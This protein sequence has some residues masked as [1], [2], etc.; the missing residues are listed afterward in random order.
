MSLGVVVGDL[1]ASADRR[2]KGGMAR[3]TGKRRAEMV[4]VSG[5]GAAGDAVLEVVF[6]AP[7]AAVEV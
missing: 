4:C 5:A 3:F 1:L 2:D 7:E 6:W